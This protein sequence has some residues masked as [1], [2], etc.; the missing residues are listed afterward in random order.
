MLAIIVAMDVNNLIGK[1]NDLPWNYP[2]DLQY[3]KEVTLNKKVLMGYNT[4]L[5]ITNRLGKA[6]PNRINYVVTSQTSLPYGAIPVNDLENFLSRLPQDED[7]FI[8]GGKQLYTSTIDKVDYLYLT[9]I[10]K[11]YEGDL[12]FP[13]FDISQFQ[14]IKQKTSGDLSFEVYKKVQK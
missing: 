4:F 11:A 14:L 6:L 7:L 8:I 1:K 13:S 3:F 12:Y 5:S 9:R 2:E 10:N